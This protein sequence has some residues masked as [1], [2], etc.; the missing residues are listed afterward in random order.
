MSESP[1][2][3]DIQ[4]KVRE[5]L[6]RATLARLRN[7]QEEAL[8]LAEEARGLDEA[9]WETHELLGDLLLEAGRSGD[10]L[11][12]YRR[13][14]ELN[15]SRGVLEEKIGR[16]AIAR[17]RQE[18]TADLSRALLEGTAKPERPK[19]SPGYSALLSLLVPG[20]GQFHNG[21]MLKGLVMFSAF[22]FLFSLSMLDALRQFT[23]VPLT[24]T[25]VAYGPRLDA[26]SFF[27]ALFTGVTAVWSL[28]LMILW[29]AAIGDAAFS[30]S[31]T[32]TSDDTGLV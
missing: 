6:G 29:I 27:S 10:A 23:V 26:G 14:R 21:D 31:R 11:K 30:A 25:G 13:A 7:R 16:A 4:L 3:A 1:S 24:Q 32:M 15:S 28:L 17:A 2:P 19:R 18:R 20:L 5:L 12:S 8:A 22:V 9:S